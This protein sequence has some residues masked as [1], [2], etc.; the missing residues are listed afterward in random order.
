MCGVFALLFI[1]VMGTPSFH[2]RESVADSY[3]M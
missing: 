1:L 3:Q 2:F